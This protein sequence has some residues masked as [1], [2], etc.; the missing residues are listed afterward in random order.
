MMTL[1]DSSSTQ[2]RITRTQAQMLKNKA[3]AG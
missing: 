3:E 2:I 1:E